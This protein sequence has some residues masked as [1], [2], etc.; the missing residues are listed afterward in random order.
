MTL[1]SQYFRLQFQNGLKFTNAGCKILM[2][3]VIF[4][5]DT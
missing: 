3:L 2:R 1:A 5:L 4:Y